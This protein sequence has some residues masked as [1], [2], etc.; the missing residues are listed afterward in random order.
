[1]TGMENYSWY[2][3]IRRWVQFRTLGSG[4]GLSAR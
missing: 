1:M 4:S 3:D 2:T